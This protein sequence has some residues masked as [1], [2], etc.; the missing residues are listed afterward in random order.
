MV[1]LDGTEEPID[2]RLVVIML[3]ALDDN[4]LQAV[5]KLVAALLGEL[6]TKEVAGLVDLIVGAVLVFLRDA[7]TDTHDLLAEALKQNVS[8]RIW[9]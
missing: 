5:D 3:L 6:F 8:K 1:G 7:V 2:R 4:L 9:A